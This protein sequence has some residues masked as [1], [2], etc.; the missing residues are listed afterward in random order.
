LSDV[1]SNATPTP[2][3]EDYKS[4]PSY[5]GARA[6]VIL[7]GVLLAIAFIMLVVGLIMRMTGH[8]PGQASSAPAS[9]TLAPG[10]KIVSTDVTETRLILRVRSNAGD[11]IDIIDTATG[12]LVGQVKS[13]TK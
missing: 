11:E 4:S 3:N 9:F 7:L 12:R 2:A 1:T 5:R 10:A 13:A 8:G 6:A